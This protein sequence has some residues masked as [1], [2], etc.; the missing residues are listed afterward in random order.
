MSRGIPVFPEVIRILGFTISTPNVHLDIE[1]IT[2][3]HMVRK[4]PDH[5]VEPG[6]GLVIGAAGNTGRTRLVGPPPVHATG[7]GIYGP[8]QGIPEVGDVVRL[9]GPIPFHDGL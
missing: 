6:I 1:R 4:P 8:L 5:S 2:P 9:R 7:F 3:P